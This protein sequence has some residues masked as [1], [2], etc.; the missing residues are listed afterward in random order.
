[1]LAEGAG[2]E[3]CSII[4]PIDQEILLLLQADSSL[5]VREIGEQV[6]LTQTPC[7]R[8]IQK[9]ESDG[10]IRRRVALVDPAAVNLGVIAL[11]QVR[12]NEHGAEW[13]NRFLDAVGQFPEIVEAYRTSGETD[14]ML[15]VMVPTIAAF[16]AFYKELIEAVDLYDVR[17]TFVMETLKSTTALPLHYAAT[18]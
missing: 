14:Y 18:T 4:D 11:V 2:V 15:K 12:T 1:M 13:L 17:S 7:W 9:L 16:D 8:R 3:Y 6:G 10:V 5:S